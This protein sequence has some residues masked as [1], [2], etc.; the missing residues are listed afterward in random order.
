[1]KGDTGGNYAETEVSKMAKSNFFDMLPSSSL[2]GGNYSRGFIRYEQEMVK[3]FSTEGDLDTRKVAEAVN[4]ASYPDDTLFHFCV[5]L[6]LN[7]EQLHEIIK[8]T[9]RINYSDW[10]NREFALLS[11]KRIYPDKCQKYGLEP[12]N[13]FPGDDFFDS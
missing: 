6:N 11:V 5:Q 2:V 4:R 7:E 9:L 12:D 10:E 3:N 13:D 1:M 8:E